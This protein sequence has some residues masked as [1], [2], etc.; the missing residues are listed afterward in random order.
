MQDR[1]PLGGGA[2]PAVPWQCPGDL[3]HW[4]G[5]SFFICQVHPLQCVVDGLDRAAKTQGIA[6]LF[7]G[8]IRFADQ[9]RPHLPLMGGENERFAP[10]ET[11]PRSDIP[12]AASLLEEF[13]DEV[14]GDFE[15]TRDLLLGPFLVIVG[16]TMRSRKSKEMVFLGMRQTYQKV[17]QMGMVLFKML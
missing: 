11:M 8:Q 6:N 1:S 12:G 17:P 4:R 7:Q 15:P 14:P 9:H 2:T 16:G 3:V 5:A 13:F 10:G